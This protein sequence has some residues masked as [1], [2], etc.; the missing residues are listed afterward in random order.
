MPLRYLHA[1]STGNSPSDAASGKKLSRS[2]EG[3]MAVIKGMDRR[4]FMVTTLTVGGGF[5]LALTFPRIRVEA[6]AKVAK[7][8]D[9]P[10]E[11]LVG[12]GETEINPWLV[13][14]PDDTV[15]IR[16][17]QSEMGQATFTSCSKMVCEELECDWSKV[18]AEYASANRHFRENKV[19]G[20]MAT[21]ASGGVRMSRQCLQQA[22]ASAR[23][24]LMAAAADVWGVPRPEL[25]V[26][27]GII[28]HVPTGRTLRYGQVA[29][30]AAAVKLR[31]E[32]KIKTPDQFTLMNKPTQFLETPL[33]VDGSVTYGI[34]VRLPGMLY[35]AAKASPVFL[36]K[37][38]KYDDA[39]VK[40][41]P[42]VHSVV[43]FSGPDIEAG[44]AV[45]ADKVVEAVYELPYLDHAFMEPMNCTAHVTADRVDVWVGTQKPDDALLDAAKLTGI[46]QENVYIHNCFIGGGF[47][48]RN[49][50]DNVRQAVMIAKQVDRPVKVVWSREETTRHG[51]Y[52]PMRVARIQAGLGSDGM[53]VAWINRVIGIDQNP[54]QDTAQTVRGLHQIPYSIP[55]QRFDYHLR[56]THVPTGVWTSVGR[57]QNEF[58]LESFMDELAHAVGKDPYQYRRALIDG[59]A[60]FPRAKSWVKVLDTAAEKSGWGKKLP[61]GTGMGIA[62]GDGRRPGV[63]EVTI[64]AVVATVSVSKKGEVRVERFDVAMDTGQFLVN[65]LA[66]ERQIE[67]QMVMGLAA[68]LRQEIT[69]EKGRVVQSNFHDY[70]LVRA[71][72]MPEI[73][74]HFVRATDEPI[75]GIGEEALGWVAPSVCNA[76]FAITGKRIR[77]LPLKNHNLSAGAA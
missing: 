37:V 24:R 57:S 54:P 48:R 73:R 49:Y 29:M 46:P 59:N 31:E 33:R 62:I 69:V 11:S 26:K 43:E 32:P 19:Y 70:P 9:K 39:G 76:I 55:N 38:R 1:D 16:V 44:V 42:G 36:G 75:V 47:G 34:D 10:W 30:K 77:S 23:E 28:T 53:P 52:R 64:C 45:V 6:A 71:T 17:A 5:A 14:A 66:A 13:V 2:L 74:I 72:E 60:D 27:D 7:I 65:P 8:P 61:E 68:V 35:A 4:E 40:N 22:G 18:R 21:N 67:M 15:T 63:K 58:Y 25:T 12:R 51:Y 3:P 20:R 56:Q 41:R 50:N